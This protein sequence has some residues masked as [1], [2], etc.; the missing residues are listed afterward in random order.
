MKETC[1]VRKSH[2]SHSKRQAKGATESVNVL[3]GSPARK[4]DIMAQGRG[5]TLVSLSWAGMIT[6]QRCC[7]N[8]KNGEKWLFSTKMFE[9]RKVTGRE[10]SNETTEKQEEE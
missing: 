6:I 1:R 9:N 8:K 4:H 3:L 2:F 5:A 10:A 7:Y